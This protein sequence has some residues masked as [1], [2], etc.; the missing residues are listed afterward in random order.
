MSKL[1]SSYYSAVL[2]FCRRAASVYL[3][4]RQYQVAAVAAP[5][6]LQQQ[7]MILKLTPTPKLWQQQPMIILKVIPAPSLVF[8]HRTWKDVRLN[9]ANTHTPSTAFRH[10]PPNSAGFSYTTEGALF[11]S[12]QLSTDAVSAFRKVPVLI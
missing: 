3:L 10:I 2:R 12:A 7:P 5:K 4:Q 6:L 9:Q 11:I 1:L 8:R